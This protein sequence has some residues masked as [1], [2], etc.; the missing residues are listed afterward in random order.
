[1][2]YALALALAVTAAF[3]GL[4]PDLSIL[5]TETTYWPDSTGQLWVHPCSACA[6]RDGRFAGI[7]RDFPANTTL[8]MLPD[9][10]NPDKEDTVSLTKSHY[11]CD[12]LYTKWTRFWRLAVSIPVKMEGVTRQLVL[13]FPLE[14]SAL[15]DTFRIGW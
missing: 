8:L 11:S 13:L 15:A 3:A 9:V 10:G 7:D 6:A 1:M 2:K 12:S 5:Q 4:I 14:D